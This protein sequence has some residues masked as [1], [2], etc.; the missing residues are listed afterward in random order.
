MKTARLRKAI[1]AAP[2]VHMRLTFAPKAGIRR[3][4]SPVGLGPQGC[5]FNPLPWGALSEGGIL[6]KRPQMRGPQ[7]AEPKKGMTDV[8]G[9]QDWR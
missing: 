9:P 7:G 8:C 6:P 3:A 1:F 4:C 2:V 5:V